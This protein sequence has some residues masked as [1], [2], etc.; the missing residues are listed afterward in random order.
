MRH[1]TSISQTRSRPVLMRKDRR[2]APVP[3]APSRPPPCCSSHHAAFL[4]L[5]VVIRQPL[6]RYRQHDLARSCRP[7]QPL[8]RGLQP[9]QKAAAPKG[10]VSKPRPQ[11]GQRVSDT[12]AR[13]RR[14]MSGSARAAMLPA[15]RSRQ[16][17]VPV[18]G[19]TRTQLRQFKILTQP[20]ARL[21]LLGRTD[22]G[23]RS[24]S[25]CAQVRSAG[26]RPDY[27][28]FSAHHPAR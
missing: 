12:V 1:P 25:S 21:Q 7:S 28:G 27:T 24:C 18:L 3:F 8:L 22:T 14:S 15:D 20:F 26:F 10:N 2:S 17:A 4:C 19:D 5:P 16:K 9:L 23:C 6:Q 11:R 13:C